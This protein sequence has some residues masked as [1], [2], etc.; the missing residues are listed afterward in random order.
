MQL[1]MHFSHEPNIQYPPDPLDGTPVVLDG[2]P[3]GGEHRQY[4]VDQAHRHSAAIHINVLS[5]NG[6]G[7]WL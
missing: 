1:K 6:Y 7:S 5:Q 2:P 4:R 3:G